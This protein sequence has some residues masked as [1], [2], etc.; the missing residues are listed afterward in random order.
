LVHKWSILSDK[1]IVGNYLHDMNWKKTGS[2]D[3]ASFAQTCHRH[4]CTLP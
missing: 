1:I 2:S 3:I 4:R